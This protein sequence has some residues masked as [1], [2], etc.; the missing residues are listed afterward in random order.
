MASLKIQVQSLAIAIESSGFQRWG[1]TGT[2][3]LE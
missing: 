2:E 1:E 3:G